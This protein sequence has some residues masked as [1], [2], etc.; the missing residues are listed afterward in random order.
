MNRFITRRL[1]LGLAVPGLL[2]LSSYTFSSAFQ[3]WEQDSASV[4]NY[5]AGYAALA[6][7]ASTAWYNPAGITRFKHQQIVV[8]A[9]AV[10]TD[11]KYKGSVAVTETTPKVIAI[12]TFPFRAV[13]AP[14][15]T[16]TYPSVTAQ[17][18]VF[19]VI[20]NL[21]Y[22]TPI[23]DK[24]GF[25]FSVSVPFGLK[26]DY[27]RSTPL[28]YA[29]TLTSISVID[30]SPSI[31][32][33]VTDKAS[34]GLGFDV[35]K[36]WAEFNSDGVLLAATPS[37]TSAFPPPITTAIV[38][39]ASASA[40]NKASGVGYGFH[41]GGLYEFTENTRVGLSYHS[42][43][44]HHLS[45]NSTFAGPA[46][47][48][49]NHGSIHSARST[50]NVTL[51]PYTSLSAYHRINPL[52]AVMGTVNYTQWSTFKTLNL[53]GVAGAVNA[54]SPVFVAP[55]KN[56]KVTIPEN[57]QDTWNVSVGADYYVTD[58]IT[59]RGAVGYDQTP[60]EDKTRNVQLPD[61]DRYIIALGGH[62][63]ATKAVGVDLGWSHFFFHQVNINPP[64][65]AMGGQTVTVN[66]NVKGGADVLAVQATWDIV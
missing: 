39:I 11:F 52:I 5:H 41:L 40:T 14:P 29:A 53:N 42:Q 9:S 63:Q 57:Y 26:T 65:Q 24:L 36:V 32:F 28:R 1:M 55:S 37:P 19:T 8:G 43:V 49:L 25:G 62:F 38:P 15:S 35:Q 13:V 16:F 17:G 31:G 30:I 64:P 4:G 21:H 56:I 34:L 50:T 3:L 18:G 22:V 66:G 2:G 47:V 61:N 27:G 20:P 44:V 12:P 7:D 60:V 46:A 58:R 48:I 45:G 33:K 23:N 10:M 54:P 59:L 51:P 6:N